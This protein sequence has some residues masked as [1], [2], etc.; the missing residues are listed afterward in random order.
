MRTAKDGDNPATLHTPFLLFLFLLLTM[1][2]NLQL[3]GVPQE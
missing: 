2:F 1:G 3:F